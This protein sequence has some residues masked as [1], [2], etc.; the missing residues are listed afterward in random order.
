MSSETIELILQHEHPASAGMLIFDGSVVEVFGFGL[1]RSVRLH[2]R[3][4]A[5]VELNEEDG[6]FSAPSLRFEGRLGSTGWTQVIDPA[7]SDKPKLEQF[8]AAVEAAV[9]D[10]PEGGA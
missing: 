9:S 10:S 2:V 8:A 4:I 7:E 3:Q 1:D 6:V 5:K